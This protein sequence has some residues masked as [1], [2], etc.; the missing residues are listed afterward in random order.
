MDNLQNEGNDRTTQNLEVPKNYLSEL[1][2]RKLGNGNEE[3][4]ANGLGWL[5]IGLGLTELL[6][7]RAVCKFLGVGERTLLVRLMGLREIASG[8]G[9]FSQRTPAEWMWARVGGDVIDLALLGAA[10]QSETANLAG[11]ALATT[12]VA[13]VTALDICCAQELTRKKIGIG[14]DGTLRIK[15]SILINR[16][17]Q[18]VYQFWRHFEN[19]PKFMTNLDSVCAIGEK[20]SDWVAKLPGGKKKEWDAEIADDRPNE[21]IAWRTIEGG[22]V[23]HSGMVRFQSMPRRGTLV[24][25]EMKIKPLAAHFLAIFAKM[26][27]QSPDQLVAEDLRHLKQIMETGQIVTTE[28]Q[29]AGR[30]RGTSWKYDWQVH[31]DSEAISTEL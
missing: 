25:V 19:L 26:F 4:L 6:A 30:S 15:K 12:T 5:S 23:S 9:I 27:G 13:G 28:G 16:E 24:T 18:D 22:D 2:R 21:L 7:P 8:L 14:E 29:S 11:V 31:R 20:Q 1:T 17:P 3:R 10:F